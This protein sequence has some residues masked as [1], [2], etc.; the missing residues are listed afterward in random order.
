MVDSGIRT[1]Y[2]RLPRWHPTLVF[3]KTPIL[4][5][6]TRHTWT[7]RIMGNFSKRKKTPTTFFS[8]ENNNNLSFVSL[9]VQRRSVCT[10]FEV[11][12]P[13]ETR[14]HWNEQIASNCQW[15]YHVNSP[16]FENFAKCCLSCQ[17]PGM[18]SQKSQNV[19]ANK[20]KTPCAG[21]ALHCFLSCTTAIKKWN[22]RLWKRNGTL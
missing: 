6:W 9:R 14:E 18:K 5:P 21:L 17:D 7:L 8:T 10:D 19:L 11:E 12:Y 1:R 20:I 16:C 2:F 3:Y 13:C 4:Q 22:I 15:L